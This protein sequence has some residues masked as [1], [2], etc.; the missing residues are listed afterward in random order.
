MAS[1]IR[2][3][4]SK[5]S[6]VFS[7]NIHVQYFLFEM[8][9]DTVFAEVV[10]ASGSMEGSSDLCTLDVALPVPAV[11]CGTY[12]QKNEIHNIEPSWNVNTVAH[13]FK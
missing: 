3:D 9:T 12:L 8:S 1:E 13:C 4:Q 2:Y 10:G 7:L 6:L 11:D 5:H